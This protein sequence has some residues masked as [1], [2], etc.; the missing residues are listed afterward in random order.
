MYY[1]CKNNAKRI[2]T[3][4]KRPISQIVLMLSIAMNR[5]EHVCD[6]VIIKHNYNYA[7]VQP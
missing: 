1:M 7:Y 6:T 2:I 5:A 3:R 4:N